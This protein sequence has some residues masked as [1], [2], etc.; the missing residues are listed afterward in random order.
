MR[1]I[2]TMTMVVLLAAC[3]SPSV[4]DSLGND[5]I[6]LPERA[7]PSPSASSSSSTQAPLPPAPKA[8]T[9]ALTVSLAGA[10][11]GTVGSTPSGLTCAGTTCKGTFAKGTAVTLAASPAAG[12]LFA[13]WA[14]GCTGSGACVAKVDRDV[15]ISAQLESIEGKWSGTYTNGR[16]VNGCKFANAGNLDITFAA[17][18]AAFTDTGSITGLEIRQASNCALLGSVTGTAPVTDVT[19]ATT[20]LTGTWTFNPQGG[21]SL[22]FPFTGKLIGKT[23]TGTWTC[24]TC[25]GSFTLTKP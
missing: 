17:N 3:G 5:D 19:V 4:E 7:P 6:K 16:D 20:G 9:F 24:A 1:F 12:S 14:G 23:F 13:A 2:V 21:G 10:G 25:T 8:E 22:A 11:K 15:T 18:G